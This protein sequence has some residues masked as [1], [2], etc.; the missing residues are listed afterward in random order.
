MSWGKGKM[1]DFAELLV[2]LPN[3]FNSVIHE[4]EC[5]ICSHVSYDTKMAVFLE[6]LQEFNVCKINIVM[7]VIP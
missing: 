4:Q 6:K 1:L 3:E 2:V 7:D 5:K